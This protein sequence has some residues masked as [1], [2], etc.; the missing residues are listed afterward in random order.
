MRSRKVDHD[1]AY[2]KRADDSGIALR[3]TRATRL[4]TRL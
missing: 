2:K 3:T 4:C 1:F